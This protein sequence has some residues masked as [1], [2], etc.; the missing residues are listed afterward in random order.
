MFERPACGTFHQRWKLGPYRLR[1]HLIL[2]LSWL[3]I[4]EIRS[5]KGLAESRY[6]MSMETLLL[7][8]K[9]I[10]PTEEVIQKALGKCYAIYRELIDAITGDEYGLTLEWK[11]YN[12]GKAWLGKAAHKKKTIF[13]LSVWEDFFKISFYFTEKTRGGV[14]ELTIDDGIKSSFSKMETA[15]KLVP[16]QMDIWRKKQLKDALEIVKYKKTLK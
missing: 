12:D 3:E 6:Q 7:K 5:A 15:G 9:D 4:P 2:Y 1:C 8:N 11:F 16:L 14:M 10:F 13:W